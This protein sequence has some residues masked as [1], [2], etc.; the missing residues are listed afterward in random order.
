MAKRVDVDWGAFRALVVS[1]LSIREVARRLGVNETTALKTASRQKWGIA[2]LHGRGHQPDTSKK[3]FAR[4]ERTLQAGKEFYREADGKTK[5]HL[6]KAVVSA[7]KTL[8]DMPGEQI[9][10]NHQALHSVAK[11]ASSVF[12]WDADHPHPFLSIQGALF[13]LAPDQ[14]AAAK[15]ASLDDLLQQYSASNPV[16]ELNH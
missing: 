5:F 15:E 12:H 4:T 14:L 2:Q 13:C 1:G 9:I 11:T 16:R 3:M 8:S 10:E 7:S 6:A